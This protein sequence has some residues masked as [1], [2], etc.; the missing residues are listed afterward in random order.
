M[1]EA[2]YQLQPPSQRG[3]LHWHAL[4]QMFETDRGTLSPL[5]HDMLAHLDAALAAELPPD[6]TADLR[7]REPQL[8]LRA[9]DHLRFTLWSLR[10]VELCDR[11]LALPSVSTQQRVRAL[12]AKAETLRVNGRNLEAEPLYK[13]ALAHLQQDDPLYAKLLSG[14]AAVLVLTA[15]VEEAEQHLQTALR[16]AKGQPAASGRTVMRGALAVIRRRQGRLE[17]ARALLEETVAEHHAQGNRQS[18]CND[19]GNLANVM[20]DLGRFDEAESLY[21]QTATYA[22]QIGLTHGVVSAM[23]NLGGLLHELGRYDEARDCLLQG[24]EVCAEQGG[25][26]S[27]ALLAGNLAS[28]DLDSGRLDE[29][30]EGYTSAMAGLRRA[31]DVQMAAAFGSEFARLLLLM[32]EVAGAEAELQA[33][34]EVLAWKSAATLRLQA[35]APVRAAL[36]LARGDLA[37]AQVSL[38][39]ARA[40]A[41]RLGIDPGVSILAG[42]R[43]AEQALLAAQS[44][45][46][47]VAGHLEKHIAP[48]LLRAL[49]A[50]GLGSAK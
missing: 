21:R 4:C 18:E 23:L 17:E 50:R 12:M 5:V 20:R 13:E 28:V 36:Q 35:A 30:R 22:G 19:L 33:A 14:M 41:A 27:M 40:E 38:S 26:R 11:V 46:P 45:Q 6:V 39:E 32:G 42:V 37:A 24:R 10:A 31:G 47:L 16:L 1:R 34:E 43:K 29:A 44:G 8:L 9:A 25:T 2:A 49:R 48:E 3:L 15:R 7:A